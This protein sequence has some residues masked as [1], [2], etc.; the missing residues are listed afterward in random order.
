MHAEIT[1]QTILSRLEENHLTYEILHA[2][3]GL[4]FL[5][6]ERGG[7][8]L[9]PF[10][11]KN[12]A[13]LFWVSKAFASAHTFRDL[14]QRGEW[15]I[16]GDRLWIAPEVQYNITNRY[17]FDGTYHLPAQMDPGS[18]H[19]LKTGE[20]HF[21][22]STAFTLDARVLAEGKKT[23]QIRCDVQPCDDPLRC[24]EQYPDLFQGVH[25]A[26]YERVITLEEEKSDHI[27]SEGWTLVQLRPGGQLIIPTTSQAKP[28]FYRGQM[29][30]SSYQATPSHLLLNVDGIHQFK[31]G[32]KA[33]FIQGRIGYIHQHSDSQSYLLV[34]AFF[35]NPS[36]YYCEEPPLHPGEHGFSV[37]V[38]ND[39]GSL[40]GF[41]EMEVNGQTIGGITRKMK[42]SDSF[43]LWAYIG[44]PHK[45]K[46][47][48]NTLL[49][50]APV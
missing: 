15:N 44:E 40:G 31:F 3:G 37:H 41:G 43:L 45:I 48:A 16:G 32:L 5:L 30:P 28:F 24:T 23:L 13:G 50:V 17:D 20:E 9:G 14:L 7:R 42:T 46:T 4:T 18:Y 19:L 36:T 34:R 8:V 49:G 27:M 22:F 38:Y 2:P 25:Y 12:H 21:S 39:D 10:L 11:D 29:Q 6:L 47:I 26:G 33:A 1:F 35:N